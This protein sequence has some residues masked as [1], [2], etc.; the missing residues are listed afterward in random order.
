MGER[1]SYEQ[2]LWQGNGSSYIA[3]PLAC[4]RCGDWNMTPILKLASGWAHTDSVGGTMIQ[5]G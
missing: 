4:L 1:R 5:F 3:L 2:L